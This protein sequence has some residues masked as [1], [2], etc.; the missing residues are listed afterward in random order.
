MQ[1][2]FP[3]MIQSQMV[4]DLNSMS[5][6]THLTTECWI[7]P[8]F[9][10]GT[11]LYFLKLLL[12]TNTFLFICIVFKLRK[13]FDKNLKCTLKYNILRHE[14]KLESGILDHMKALFSRMLLHQLSKYGRHVVVL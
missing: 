7:M 12:K 6:Q 2:D 4:P 10:F 11:F 9:L 3:F 13:S 1:C 5:H 8:C 14:K